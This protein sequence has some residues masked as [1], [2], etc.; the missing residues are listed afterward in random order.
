ML[1]N[2]IRTLK[3]SPI[4]IVLNCME[5]KYLDIFGL[6]II[7]F[8]LALQIIKSETFTTSILLLKHSS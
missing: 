4:K 6:I 8:A 1:G 5:K 7:A 3:A 2:F